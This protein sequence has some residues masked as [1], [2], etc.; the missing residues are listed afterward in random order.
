MSS[1]VWS[2]LV[3]YRQIHVCYVL[4]LVNMTEIKLLAVA[5]VHFLIFFLSPLIYSFDFFFH[6][7]G[8]DIVRQ[9]SSRTSDSFKTWDIAYYADKC[10]GMYILF[11]STHANVVSVHV[12]TFINSHNYKTYVWRVRGNNSK[13]FYNSLW[14][15]LRKNKKFKVKCCKYKIFS[16]R[17]FCHYLKFLWGHNFSK[18]ANCCPCEFFWAF[19]YLFVV[20]I[21][22]HFIYT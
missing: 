17:F 11:T 21:L 14:M 18:I 16:M 6:K 8:Y 5:C 19:I 2:I 12:D 20:D 9:T 7:P 1:H 10:L 22:N 3:V 15:E 13:K 4:S